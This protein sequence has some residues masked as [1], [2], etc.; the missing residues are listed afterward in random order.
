MKFTAAARLL[1]CL[2]LLARGGPRAAAQSAED[3]NP[4]A[5]ISERNVFH[6]NPPPPPAPVE[7]K[8]EE[9]PEIKLSGFLRIG[10]TTHALFSCKPKDNK[11]GPIYYDLA[12][13]EK[14]GI[15]EVVKIH[16][17]KGAVEIINSGTAATLTLKEDSIKE[18][19]AKGALANSAGPPA[20]GER[21]P[22]GAEHLPAR[23]AYRSPVPGQNGGGGAGRTSAFPMPARH[24]R[25][26]Q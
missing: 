19:P 20:P 8:K 6:L 25:I 22:P 10:K 21:F 11:D 24:S 26:L 23:S 17:D 15:L 13:G 9:L 14:Q 1:G 4:Y 2:L 12:D 5:I 7:T 16:D 3:S 18:A